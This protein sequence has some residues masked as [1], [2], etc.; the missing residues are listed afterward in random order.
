MAS[1]AECLAHTSQPVT[2][3]SQHYKEK[4]RSHA[5]RDLM[6]EEA[7][8]KKERVKGEEGAAFR[9]HSACTLRAPTVHDAP[10]SFLYLRDSMMH[11]WSTG[12]ISRGAMHELEI[13]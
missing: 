6:P 13:T 11:A 8:G 10:D 7:G 4:R 9:Q 1:E 5:A 2:G 12:T 3:H